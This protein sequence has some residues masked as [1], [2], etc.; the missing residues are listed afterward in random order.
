M[1]IYII[2]INKLLAV[3]SHIR[4]VYIYIYNYNSS[5][6]IRSTYI[7]AAVHSCSSP[8]SS[9]SRGSSSSL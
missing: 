8:P 5:S 7:V 6:R 1:Y 3:V 9:S 2:I 4:S